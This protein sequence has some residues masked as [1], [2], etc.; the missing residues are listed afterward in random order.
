ML[1]HIESMLK[2]DSIINN[3]DRLASDILDGMVD[4]V[5]VIDNKGYT[6]YTN[7]SMERDL[8]GRAL[9]AKCYRV[10]EKDS[11]CR[12][13]ITETT[14]STGEIAEKEEIIGEKIFSIKSSPVRDDEGN[15][16]AVVEVFRDVTKERKLEKEI[17]KRN[18]K[19]SKDLAF[20]RKI[21]KKILPKQGKY[22]RVE[23]EYL[24]RPCEMLSGDMFDIFKID[25]SHIGFY[26]SDVVGHGV[27]ASIMTMFVKQTM[28]SIVS[29]YISPGEAMT[30]LHKNFLDLNLDV[31]SYF[32]IFYGIINTEDRVLKFVNGGHNSVP[33]HI[34]SEDIGHLEGTGYPITSLFDNIVY[35]DSQV[36]LSSGDELI[37]Y[38][39]GITEAKNREGE[40]YGFE[41]LADIVGERHENPIKAIKNSVDDFIFYE[42]EDDFTILRLKLL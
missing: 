8:Q 33:F 28:A 5:R 13:C 38:T 3:Y 42:L 17:M 14:M 37:L 36:K 30:N 12:R 20:A 18:E 35:T 34:K 7:K 6:I 9:G 16:Y 22:G 40:E 4:W 24:Y 41:R 31:E 19:M 23:M 26:V 32:T 15:I 27:T 21:Q 11:R 2:G 29:E 39:D 25:E 10:F 1:G